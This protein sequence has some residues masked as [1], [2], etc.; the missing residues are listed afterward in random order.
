MQRVGVECYQLI[1][2]SIDPKADASFRK[3]VGD[4]YEGGELQEVGHVCTNSHPD[5]EDIETA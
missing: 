4:Q 5:S 3:V 1:P 2:L